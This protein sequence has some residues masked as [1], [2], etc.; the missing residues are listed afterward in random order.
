MKE[1]HSI[2]SKASEDIA[3]LNSQLETARSEYSAEREGRATDQQQAEATAEET[4]ATIRKLEDAVAQESTAREEDEREAK[5]RAEKLQS[6]LETLQ[7][8]DSKKELPQENLDT[9][10]ISLAKIEVEGMPQKFGNQ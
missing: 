2:Q 6:E 4:K 8:G 1:G 5:S 7:E 3:D 9:P 10:S